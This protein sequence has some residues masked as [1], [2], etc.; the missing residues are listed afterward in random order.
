[1]QLENIHSSNHNIYMTNL[2]IHIIVFFILIMC[3]K[4]S[5]SSISGT[6]ANNINDAKIV[7]VI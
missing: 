6:W 2:D 3:S 4:M 1:M 7:L 5:V